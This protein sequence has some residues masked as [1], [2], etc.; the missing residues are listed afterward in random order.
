MKHKASGAKTPDELLDI[1]NSTNSN[2]EDDEIFDDEFETHTILSVLNTIKTTMSDEIILTSSAFKSAKEHPH[3]RYPERVL[4]A[5]EM[6]KKSHDKFRSISGKNMKIDYSKILRKSGMNFE[7]A[8]GESKSTMNKYPLSRTF[9]HNGKD[10]QMLPHIKI[11]KGSDDETVRIHFI[12]DSKSKKFIIGH[13]G[14]HL[15]VSRKR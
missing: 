11:G 9:K 5:F 6:L 1:L 7:I 3:Y 8:N 10:V 14:K 2:D 13:C 15:P 4:E 12:F